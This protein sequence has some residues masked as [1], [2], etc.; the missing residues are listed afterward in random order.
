MHL[1]ATPLVHKLRPGEV[2]YRSFCLLAQTL[3]TKTQDSTLG[4]T[5]VFNT[6]HCFERGRLSWRMMVS[7]NQKRALSHSLL[8]LRKGG[9]PQDYE[10]WAYKLC[11]IGKAN[12]KLRV[13][14]RFCT[15]KNKLSQLPVMMDFNNCQSLLLVR[16]NISMAG[17]TLL[18]NIVN[19]RSAV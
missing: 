8:T 5:S 19:F 18:T 10:L 11:N 1:K 13:D 17:Q 9:N 6:P 3:T 14:V 2:K 16:P 12:T 15:T 4:L 7:S